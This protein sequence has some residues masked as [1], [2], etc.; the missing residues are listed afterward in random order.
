[1]PS[2]TTSIAAPEI[3]LYKHNNIDYYHLDTIDSTNTFAKS[4]EPSP[5]NIIVVRADSQTMGRGRRGKSF[6]SGIGGLWVSIIVP[7]ADITRHFSIN[8]CLSLAIADTLETI[9]DDYTTSIKWPNDIYR[10]DR[11]ICGILL[12]N[13]P[14][15]PHHIIIGFGCNINIPKKSFPLSLRNRAT[16]LRIETGRSFSLDDILHAIIQKFQDN[17]KLS[18]NHQHSLY[19]DKLYRINTQVQINGKKGIFT[20]VS[21][22][23]YLQLKLTKNMLDIH[24]GTL[25]FL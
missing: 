19:T 6:Y 12:E 22:E 8:R 9:S 7:L 13:I 21:K 23:G 24:T 3:V 14:H 10:A 18:D 25:R 11:K 4:L 17:L 5:N 16:S 15:H 2:R 20:G 1:M